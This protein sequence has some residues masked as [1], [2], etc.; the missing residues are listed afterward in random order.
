VE[1][2]RRLLFVYKAEVIDGPPV[3]PFDFTRNGALNLADFA[4]FQ[5]CFT[6]DAGGDLSLNCLRMNSDADC[7]V[8]VVDFASWEAAFLAEGGV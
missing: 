3:A 8:D 6:G 1:F 5:T 7:D 2:E 4:G